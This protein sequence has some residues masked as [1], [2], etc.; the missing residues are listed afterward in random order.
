MPVINS[1]ST[2]SIKKLKR[3]SDKVTTTPQSTGINNRRRLGGTQGGAGVEEQLRRASVVSGGSGVYLA[4]VINNDGSVGDSE[5]LITT[6]AT[7]YDLSA[8]KRI[9]GAYF[10]TETA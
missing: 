2:S 10:P 8:D 9:L 7:A 4:N 6:R 5:L 3:V 1:L